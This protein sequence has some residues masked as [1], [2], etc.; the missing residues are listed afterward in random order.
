M[1]LFL[2]RYFKSIKEIQEMNHKHRYCIIAS[3]YQCIPHDSINVK[4]AI[5]RLAQSDLSL[6]EIYNIL[7][8]LRQ[9]HVNEI[10]KEEKQ[11]RAVL[12]RYS[13]IK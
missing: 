1:P 7:G 5:E 9:R 4:A 13:Y 12:D 11:R 8:P 10:E 2:K 6:M 3:L